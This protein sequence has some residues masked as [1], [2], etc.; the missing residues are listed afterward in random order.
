MSRG[1]WRACLRS[2]STSSRVSQLNISYVRVAPK[3]D[4]IDSDIRNDVVALLE[5]APAVVPAR[6]DQKDTFT[7][8]FG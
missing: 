6:I 7:L 2:P 1:S 3:L 8:S 5:K 4:A